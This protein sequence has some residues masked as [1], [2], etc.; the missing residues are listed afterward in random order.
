MRDGN[1]SRCTRPSP[2]PCRF[3]NSKTIKD[4]ARETLPSSLASIRN[5]RTAGWCWARAARISLNSTGSTVEPRSG[6]A[7]V[8]GPERSR[9]DRLSAISLSTGKVVAMNEFAKLR[10]SFLNSVKR[11]SA[12][13]RT[14]SIS[15]QRARAAASFSSIF[16]RTPSPCAL[17]SI[18]SRHS[19]WSSR[20]DRSRPNSDSIVL[21]GAP[22]F[23]SASWKSSIKC[24]A[25]RQANSRLVQQP[26]SISSWA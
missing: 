14:K 11:S 9:F 22:I 10:K 16:L 25:L 20:S 15:A 4:S 6:L 1:Q 18:F 2:A 26:Y 23:L 13:W 12:G 8:V 5:T 3:R 19:I 24:A 7:S 21:R 17:F